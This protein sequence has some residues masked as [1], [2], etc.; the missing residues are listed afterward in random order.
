MNKLSLSLLLCILLSVESFK[1]SADV[2]L[3]AIIGDHM[4]LQQNSTVTLWGWC[5]PNEKIRLKAD[6]DTT[7]YSTTGTSGAKWSVQ[8]KTPSAGRPFKINIKGNNAIVLQDVVVG[9]VWIC[10]GQSNMEMNMTWGL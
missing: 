2:R 6:W 9:E 5:D 1:A 7:T 10:S 4:V 8:P 3:P